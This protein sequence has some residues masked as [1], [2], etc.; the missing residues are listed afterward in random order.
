[1]NLSL[2]MIVKNEAAALPQCLNSVKGVVDEIVVLDTGSTD[3][4]VDIALEFGAKVH[5]FDWCDDFSAARNEA[6]SYVTGKWV[7]VLDADETLVPEVVPLLQQAIQQDEY[8]LINLVRQEV[9]AEQSPY[10]MVSRLFRNHPDISFSRPYHALVD[11]SVSL[12]KS[13]EPQ[14]QIGYLPQVAILHAGYQAIAINQQN[15][16]ARAAA[17]MAGFLARHPSD[18]YVC[19]K[20]GALYVQMGRVSEGIELLE[21]GLK[22]QVLNEQILYELHYHLGIAYS[23]TGNL[24][25][26]FT[27]YQAATQLSIHPLLKLGAYNNLGNILKAAGDVVA[28]KNVYETTV[29]I[30]PSFAAGYY[31]LGM[32]MKALGD[33]Q[34]AIASYQR[35]IDLKP[36]Y[37]DAYQNLGVVLLKVGRITHSLSAFRSAIALHE[38]QNPPVA[39]QLRQGLTDMG[40][41]L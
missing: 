32:A 19:S 35:A 1:M 3:N 37:A 34:G 17:A 38:Q 21:R 36:D 11:D 9:D 18:P 5:H 7:L 8:L 16:Y 39:T 41:H 23:R 24:Q 25:P 4:T 6:L 31:N 26:A 14:W 28:A 22:S 30:D 20:L 12:I 15:K 10:S 13:Q 2:C 29:Q 33:F 27:H 40:F